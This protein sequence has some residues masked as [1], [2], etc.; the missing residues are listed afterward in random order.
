MP[1]NHCRSRCAQSKLTSAFLSWYGKPNETGA[2][3]ATCIWT[4][5]KAARAANSRPDH[6]KAMRLA[7]QSYEYYDL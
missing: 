1:L 5:R 3:L 7:A 2:N 4:S 6:I